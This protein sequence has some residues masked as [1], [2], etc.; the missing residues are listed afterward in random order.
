MQVAA[1]LEDRDAEPIAADDAAEVLWAPIQGLRELQGETSPY[2]LAVNLRRACICQCLANS[3][4]QFV[5][6]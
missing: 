2:S 1:L 4:L 6:V 3:T 5:R